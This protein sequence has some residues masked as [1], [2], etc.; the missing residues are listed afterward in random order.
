VQADGNCGYRVI[1]RMLGFGEEGWAQ[2]R[3]DF[4][5]LIQLLHYMKVFLDV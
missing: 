3:R 4:M 1:A 5:K 2:V